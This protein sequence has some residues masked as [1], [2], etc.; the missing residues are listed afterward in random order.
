MK[1]NMVLALTTAIGL[2]LGLPSYTGYSGAP[3]TA[4]TCAG[5]CH[6]SGV[7]TITVSG[8]PTSYSLGQYYL[9]TAAAR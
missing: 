6:G 2:C 5:A 8:L 4:G 7:G 1:P 9:V 3:G